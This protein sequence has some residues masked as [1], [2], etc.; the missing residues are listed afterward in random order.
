MMTVHRDL[1]L[2]RSGVYRCPYMDNE[3]TGSHSVR[4]LGWGEDT[5]YGSRPNKYWVSVA[6]PDVAWT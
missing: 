3:G 6:S 2:Y 4:I 5:T 1:F